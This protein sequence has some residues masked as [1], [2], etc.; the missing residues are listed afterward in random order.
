M[1]KI[2]FGDYIRELRHKRELKLRTAAE[3][4]GI[5]SPYL[6]RIESGLERPPSRDCLERM[7]IAYGVDINELLENANNRAKEAY[8]EMVVNNPALNVFFKV[9]R[10]LPEEKILEA[11]ETVCKKNG[12]DP[13][14]F[15]DE[16]QKRKMNLPRLRKVRENLFAADIAPRWLSK[17][18]I[19]KTAYKFLEKHGLSQSTYRPPTPIEILVEKEDGIRLHIDDNMKMFKSGEPMELG[20]SHWSAHQDDVREIHLNYALDKGNHASEHR[21]RFTLGHELFH[22]LE[23][24]L[25]MDAKSRTID[26]LCRSLALEEAPV[27]KKDKVKMI[28][29]WLAAPNQPKQLLTNEDWREWQA[30]YFSACVLMPEWSVRQEFLKR[31]GT[32]EVSLDDKSQI[33]K[34]AYEAA[35]EKLCTMG[36]F[37]K[38]LNEVFDVSIQAMTIR[39]MALK[40]VY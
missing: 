33:R 21:L 4:I 36:V 22:C 5:T 2:S 19:E 38:S 34:V 11:I 14:S 18:K 30:D 20:M 24:L 40:F 10:D 3:K 7:A 28:D 31:F 26:A 6:S 12:L 15:L 27:V 35:R 1:A 29:R 39:L 37:E 13:R 32:D 17:S 9:V 8:G 16:I 25:L 23:H